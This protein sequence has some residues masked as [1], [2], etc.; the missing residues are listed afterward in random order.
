MNRRIMT[1]CTL[2]ATLVAVAPACKKT[3]SANTEK[4]EPAAVTAPKP[5]TSAPAP[6]APAP[7]IATASKDFINADP[8]FSIRLP[9][10]F[11]ADTPIQTG[12]GNTSMRFAKDGEHSGDREVRIGDLVEAERQGCYDLLVKQNVH[13]IGAGKLRRARARSAGK[14]TFVYGT[15]TASRMVDYGELKDVP[16]KQYVG[17]GSHRHARR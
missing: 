10:G 12:P 3:E 17:H 9:E 16:E 7:A 5:I 15:R 8:P 1:T 14:G 11:V 2:I 13:H 4:G 6:P